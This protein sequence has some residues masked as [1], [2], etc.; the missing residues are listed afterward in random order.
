VWSVSGLTFNYQ[1]FYVG[2]GKNR[3]INQHF[4]TRELT[5]NTLKNNKIKKIVSETGEL[6]IHYRI[7]ENLTEAEAFEIEC[8]L[9]K[10]FGR[11][12]N[13]SGILVNQTD[14]GEGHSGCHLPKYKKRKKIFQY[15][16]EGT[17]IREWESIT[18]VSEELLIVAGNISTA[19][20]RNGT[21]GG[22]IWSYNLLDGCDTKIRYQMPNK[23]ENIQQI[24]VET[25]EVI[26]IFKN[27]LEI[28]T[29]LNL[30]S[31]A[32]NKIYECI[33]GKIKTAYGYKWK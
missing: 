22:F 1:P 19:I 18:Q 16:L 24:N 11:I 3:R 25:G 2:K 30:R 8:T 6:P 21:C 7:Y 9:I 13:K 20:K 15:S 23:F 5:K 12:D 33:N 28:E 17:F 32:R 10:Q 27:A 31:G 4:S 14:G 29:T 26:R